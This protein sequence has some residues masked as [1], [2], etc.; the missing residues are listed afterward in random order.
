MLTDEFELVSVCPYSAPIM[1]HKAAAT[2]QVQ[3]AVVTSIALCLLIVVNDWSDLIVWNG[4]MRTS[5][6]I[7]Q[8]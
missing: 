5:V 3:L 4:L 1:Q 7:D 6:N 2:Q 8:A